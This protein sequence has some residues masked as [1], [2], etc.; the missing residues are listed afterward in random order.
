MWKLTWAGI[1]VNSI[2]T[3]V[4]LLGL[5]MIADRMAPQHGLAAGQEAATSAREGGV[6]HA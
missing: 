3:D 1:R 5:E 4:E 2:D 6:A